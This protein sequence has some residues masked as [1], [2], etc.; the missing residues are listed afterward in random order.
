MAW[1]G[2]G[3]QTRGPERRKCPKL[4]HL[5]RVLRARGSHPG[6]RGPQQRGPRTL[7]TPSQ[8]P[9]LTHRHTDTHLPSS[10]ADRTVPSK[11]ANLSEVREGTRCWHALQD[12]FP[13]TPL[14]AGLVPQ[15]GMGTQGS[16]LLRS[17]YWPPSSLSRSPPGPQGPFSKLSS[18]GGRGAG[19]GRS[20]R[21][22]G[23]CEEPPWIPGQGV[24]LQTD[25]SNESP[26][27]RR[28]EAAGGLAGAEVTV[29]YFPAAP[30]P[31]SATTLT[32]IPRPQEQESGFHVG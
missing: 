28:A 16:W 11:W 1:R 9:A 25:V 3:I 15:S 5:L 4:T 27:T 20:R 32:K 2:L 21:W 7:V 24:H 18:S 19:G 26:G 23:C 8:T 6:V 13:R 10:F 31:L 17:P 12:H 30:P 22:G 29:N 14:I